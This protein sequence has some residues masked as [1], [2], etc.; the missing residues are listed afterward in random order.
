MNIGHNIKIFR[1]KKGL[2]QK[3]LAEKIGVTSVTIQ[4][5]ENNRRRPD[6][7]VLNEIADALSCKLLDLVE[8]ETNDIVNRKNPQSY[9]LEQYIHT[10]GY[11]IITD[12]KDGYL[13]IESKDGEFE[14]EMKDLEELQTNSRS[15]IEYKIHEIINK[16][17]KIGK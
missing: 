6:F 12:P 15:F 2:T 7:V 16:S 4:N 5:Y 11:K 10:L 9:Y 14:I 3:D 17:R 1:K 8:N 13:I